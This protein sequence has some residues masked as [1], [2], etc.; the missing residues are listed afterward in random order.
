M[1]TSSLISSLATLLTPFTPY[2]LESKSNTVMLNAVDTQVGKALA[3]RVN[4]IW[5]LLYPYFEADPHIMEVLEEIGICS[6][7]GERQILLRYAIKKTLT[8]NSLLIHELVFILE[9]SGIEP[10]TPK[11]PGLRKLDF[12]KA[13]AEIEQDFLE[14]VFVTTPVLESIRSGQ[15]TI[16]LGRK[17]SGKTALC[18]K[19]F[20]DLKR[21]GERVSLLTPRDLS[22]NSLKVLEKESIDISESFLLSWKY[23]FMVEISKYVIEDAKNKYGQN[24]AKW[25]EPIKQ[26]RAFLAQYTSGYA[27]FIDKAIKTISSI[28]KVGVKIVSAELSAELENRTDESS[29]ADKVDAIT[30]ALREA[31]DLLFTKPLYILI[32]KIDEIW[33]SSSQSSE[34]IIG[35]LRASKEMF[36]QLSSV[37]I[38][39]F[40]RSDIYDTLQFNDSDKFHSLE[41][42]IEW[43]KQRLKWLI[44]LRARTST[45]LKGKPEPDE[46]WQT[47][48]SP[49]IN[50][51]DSFEF[52]IDR[53]LMRP[54]DLIQLCN[55]CKDKAVANNNTRITEKD[56]YQALPQ[57]SEWKLNDLTVEYKVQ[58]P[59]LGNVI[60]GAFYSIPPVVNRDLLLT[61]L[62]PITGKIIESF[63]SQ[64]FEPI[65]NLLQIIYN[66]GFWGAVVSDEVLYSFYGKSI[67]I[68]FIDLFE[69]HPAFRLALKI[70]KE[71]HSVESTTIEGQIKIAGGDITIGP[72]SQTIVA[73]S[74]SI[75]S[76]VIQEMKG[77][78]NQTIKANS[79]SV[80]RE[81]KQ[82]PK[83][84]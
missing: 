64:Y 31:L 82:K 81:V 10:D 40:L 38:V 46:I 61:R 68:P 37:H 78:G 44:T 34:L 28:K 13:S 36:E 83:K 65:D 9:S 22:V 33:N 74:D 60:L 16:V 73:G 11:G 8:N 71:Y 51:K 39:V 57:Y 49:K 75:I 6:E 5:K 4:A 50:G 62:K 47:F 80:I 27:N 7:I 23:I 2:F 63:G 26:A 69:I 43:D 84:K 45:G 1:D 55:L 29:L 14:K 77:E 12:G 18:L 66:I 53:T 35:L 42:R 21:Q 79:D 30:N 76:N 72:G 56:I 3:S 48:F 67:V 41:E 32:D 52:L 17:G 70:E 19:L 54:R 25:P 59:F 24:Y 15:K 20:N 58:Y